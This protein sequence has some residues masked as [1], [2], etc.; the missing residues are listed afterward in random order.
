LLERTT[1]A[2]FDGVFW[3]PRSRRFA[4][5]WQDDPADTMVVDRRALKRAWAEP[6]PDAHSFLL[7]QAAWLTGGGSLLDQRSVH[8]TS[9]HA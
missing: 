2:R 3:G 8:S 5:A 4:D 9:D 1:K 6:E 7:L